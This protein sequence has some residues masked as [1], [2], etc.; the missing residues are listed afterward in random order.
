V[1]QA[2]DSLD[3]FEAAITVLRAEREPTGIEPGEQQTA[4]PGTT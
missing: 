2:F 3:D 4:A 1:Y